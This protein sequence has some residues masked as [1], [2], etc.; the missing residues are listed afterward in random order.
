MIFT[1]ILHWNRSITCVFHIFHVYTWGK[2]FWQCFYINFTFRECI[3]HVIYIGFTWITCLL[4][5]LHVLSY[6]FIFAKKGNIP[7]S[8]RVYSYI[9]SLTFDSQQ[10]QHRTK[11]TML[12]A[13]SC[14]LIKEQQILNTSQ[15][16]IQTLPTSSLTI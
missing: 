5:V 1:W 12:L 10:A 16:P 8:G 3:L 11:Y 2:H 14:R 4:H 6:K 13:T 7:C 15:Q 9:P